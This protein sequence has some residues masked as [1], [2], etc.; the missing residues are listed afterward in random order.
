MFSEYTSGVLLHLHEKVGPI[1]QSQLYRSAILFRN[2]AFW[3]SNAKIN[4]GQASWMV[5]NTNATSNVD[6]F[7]NGFY[8]YAWKLYL[9]L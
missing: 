7:E 4:I 2:K 1:F 3:A 8:A 5:L 9:L 6:F